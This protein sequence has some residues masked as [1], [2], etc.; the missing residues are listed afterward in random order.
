MKENNALVKNIRI[1]TGA[2]IVA[3]I[4]FVVLGARSNEPSRMWQIYLVN[5]L[6]WTGVAQAG[7]IFSAVLEITNA[8]W[9]S[10]MRSVAESLVSFLPV[11]IVLLL[12]MII[13]SPHIF[14]WI[15]KVEIP[16]AKQIYLNLPFLYGRNLLGMGLLTFLSIVFINK[17]R[18]A[19]TGLIERPRKFAVVLL[20]LYAV[21]YTFVAFDFIMSLSPHWY[22]TIM[23]MHFFT[24]CFYTGLSV[25]LMSAVFGRWHLFPA[26][27]MRDKDFHDLGKLLFGFAIFWM[28]LVWSQFLVIWYGNMPEETEFLHLRFYEHPWQTMTWSFIIL[29]FFVPLIILLNKK[30]KTNQIVSSIVATL[31]LLGS[32]VHLYVLVVPSI[33]PHH[34]YIGIQEFA[35]SLGFIGLFIL[36]HDVGLKYWPIPD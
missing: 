16:A 23:G 34:L 36:S 22:S 33:T 4:V 20:I 5:F 17:R 18:S 19:D 8:R 12:I 15:S 3:G 24:A 21:I 10:R 27:F 2:L 31:I 6:L 7:A 9:G 29:G 11:S 28:S 32:F 26:D 13:G 30:G 1:I 25:I 35:V 14:P